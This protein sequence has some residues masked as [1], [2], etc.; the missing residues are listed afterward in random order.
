MCF[1]PCWSLGVSI[2]K[3]SCFPAC[4]SVHVL[5]CVCLPKHSPWPSPSMIDAQ[6]VMQLERFSGNRWEVVPPT[7]RM[8]INQHAAQAWLALNNLMVGGGGYAKELRVGFRVVLVARASGSTVC[9]R[10]YKQTGTA[11][12]L[13]S[14]ALLCPPI[15]HQTD[16]PT[17]CGMHSGRVCRSSRKRGP[18]MTWM[19]TG[20]RRCCA[21][22]ELW[23]ARHRH[24][25]CM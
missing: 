17:T 13:A 10:C 21:S 7:E 5:H 12:T 24:P 9:P 19:S 11:A 3:N 8:R 2:L 6:Y 16:P 15:R 20:V 22:S 23:G 25:V 1:F 4:Q 18:S 14:R